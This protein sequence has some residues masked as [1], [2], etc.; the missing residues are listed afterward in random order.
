MW[1]F[2][3][4]KSYRHL[5]KKSISWY[6]LEK[7]YRIYFYF[8][9]PNNK[10]M[11]FPGGTNGK[12][13]H[14]PTPPLH[15]STQETLR[16]TGSIPFPWIRKIL[17][18]RAWQSIPVFLPGESSWTEEPGRLQSMRSQRVGHDCA[19]KHTHAQV[20]GPQCISNKFSAG[21]DITCPGLLSKNHHQS[22]LA[23]KTSIICLLSSYYLL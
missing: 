4:K 9:I 3:V 17:W 12:E 19:T 11:G 21:A 2:Y 1:F 16:D 13:S 18:M 15:A 14:P 7:M 6:T 23:L 5:V 8:L 20:S 22:S 10:F